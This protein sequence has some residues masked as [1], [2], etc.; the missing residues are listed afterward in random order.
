VYSVTEQSWF[1]TAGERGNAAS[2]IDRR[3]GDGVGW[4]EGNTVTPLVHGVAYFAR[5]HEELSQVGPGDQVWFLDWRG[6]ASQRLAGD[7]TELGS[8][9]CQALESGAQ[10]RALVWRSHPDR[11]GFS[12]HE[13]LHVAHVVNGAGGEVLLDERVRRFGSHHQKIVL[14]HRADRPADDVA[15]VGGI[16][17]CHGRADDEVHEG[18]PQPIE[19]DQR[20]GPGPAW[21]DVQLEV[22][23]PAVGDLSE[24]FRERWTD[25]TPLGRRICDRRWF[26]R[27]ARQ[28]RPA[29]ELPPRPL[30][31]P[32][33]G[34][35]A[36]QVLRTY[37]AKRVP[38]PFAPRGERSIARAYA[39]ALGRARSLIYVEDQYLWSPEVGRVFAQALTRS[40]GLR[41]IAVVPR[42]PDRDGAVS[43]PLNRIGQQ[44]AL[45]IVR[46]A[47]G[48]RVA[49][50]DLE[51]EAGRPIYVHAKLCVIDDVW[52]A[53]G[54]DNLNL[55]SWTHDSEVCCG[56][57][58][59]ARDQRAPRIRAGSET[60]RGCCPVSSAWPF[61]ASTSA[62][63]SPIRSSLICERASMRGS[64]WPGPWTPGTPGGGRA[65]APPDAREGTNPRPSL[66]SPPGGPARFTGLAWTPT[67][68]PQISSVPAASDATPRPT[69]R[70]PSWRRGAFQQPAA[71]LVR[72]VS[73]A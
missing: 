47:G 66:V 58:D 69:V 2:E 41:M 25:P 26:R 14:V 72:L 32:P 55:R 28:L 3:R 4:T 13:A 73:W 57:I 21:H 64:A 42:H 15:F 24:I 1:L 44:E 39:K 9:L 51:N 45:R 11:S 34:N 18:D 10:V 46:A 19:M 49:V 59:S 48:D 17:L 35:V 71:A 33:A 56:V 60:G 40:S 50:Y 23:G 62:L 8:V 37:P 31:L 29:G 68:D 16:D 43:G 53:V 7:G 22:R 67:G 36:V 38:F 65:R 63:M 5:L 61:G 54:S 6:D 70:C 52:M 27:L 20:Y 12:E 30:A